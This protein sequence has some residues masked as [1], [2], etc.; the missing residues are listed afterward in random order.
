[1][2]DFGIDEIQADFVAEIKLRN[3]NREY[4]L[5]RVAETGDLEKDI[6]DLENVVASKRRIKDIIIGELREVLKKHPSPRRTGLVYEDELSEIAE[7]DET[8]EYHV[9]LFISREG[10]FKNHRRISPDVKRAEIQ[11]GRRTSLVL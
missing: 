9:T 6:A 1:M 7:E 5:K 3:I 11:G 8:E 2:T 10:Y 4:I